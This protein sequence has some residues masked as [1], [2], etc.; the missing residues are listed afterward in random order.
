MATNNARARAAREHVKAHPGTKY[1]EALR[2]VSAEALT[3][4]AGAPG[5]GAMQAAKGDIPRT[6]ISPYTQD[7]QSNVQEGLPNVTITNVGGMPGCG[8]TF[9][10][11][12]HA[13]RVKVPLR[14]IFST[15][16]EWT[17][18]TIP[19]ATVVRPLAA[20][21]QVS[22]EEARFRSFRTAIHEA[23]T[24]DAQTLIVD[25]SNLSLPLPQGEVGDLGLTWERLGRALTESGPRFFE[26]IFDGFFSVPH[27]GGLPAVESLVDA[28]SR[29]ARAR[30]VTAH[31]IYTGCDYE[32][33]IS[34]DRIRTRWSVY[35]Y[36]DTPS[37]PRARAVPAFHWDLLFS[38]GGRGRFWAQDTHGGWE[39]VA[40]MDTGVQPL[41][42]DKTAMDFTPASPLGPSKDWLTA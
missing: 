23:M 38:G 22:D 14:V 37:A 31:V 27:E 41:I 39:P 3:T 8:K 15:T 19:G 4:V 36:A 6:L 28:V 5:R 25:L 21:S 13:R 26:I 32:R 11:M 16:A 10:L 29:T 30:A 33:R 9:A 24:N 1:T 18:A 42:F 12:D 2:I 17:D 35:G 40:V 7:A 20:P 34:T